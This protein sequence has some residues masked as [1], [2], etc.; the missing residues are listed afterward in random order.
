VL[1]LLN[2]SFGSKTE[3]VAPRLQ[4][5]NHLVAVILADVN[6]EVVLELC[7][8]VLHELRIR[9]G[10]EEGLVDF[11]QLTDNSSAIFLQLRTEVRQRLHAL[12][13]VAKLTS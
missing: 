1:H 10:S 11:L 13:L 6:Q 8:V 7:L 9:F 3:L 4:T 2:S 5:L 12:K